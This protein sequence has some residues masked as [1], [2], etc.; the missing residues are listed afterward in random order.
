MFR[1]L[2]NA[3]DPKVELPVEGSQVFVLD[4]DQPSNSVHVAIYNPHSNSFDSDGGWFEVD[5]IDYWAY[6]PSI[7]T[8]KILRQLGR[9]FIK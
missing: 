1:T 9:S 2:F 7:D 5:E 3:K 4:S 6:V 8:A